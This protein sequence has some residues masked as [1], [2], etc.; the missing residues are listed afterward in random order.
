[1]SPKAIEQH[2]LWTDVPESTGT[3]E[4]QCN[5]K[6]KLESW[7]SPKNHARSMLDRFIAL[8]RATTTVKA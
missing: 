1:M 6:T 2:L 7:T 5:W 4:F 8:S 3:W